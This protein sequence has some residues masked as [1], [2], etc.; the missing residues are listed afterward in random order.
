MLVFQLPDKIGEVRKRLRIQGERR[1][2]YLVIDIHVERVTGNPI[3]AKTVCDFA[4]SRLGFVRVA[5]L[6]KA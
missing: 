3:G 2:V 5:R 1:V 6:L 4:Q